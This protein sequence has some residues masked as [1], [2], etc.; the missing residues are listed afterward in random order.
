MSLDNTDP[1][2]VSS[3]DDMVPASRPQGPFPEFLPGE[4]QS[5]TPSAMLR[6]WESMPEVEG[7]M[8]RKQL[9]K[10][11]ADPRGVMASMR[12]PFPDMESDR[13]RASLYG[14]SGG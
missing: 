1:S 9:G 5:K 6:P 10:L 7:A 14:R 11:K 2:L 12:N 4:F 13:M 3:V 8:I